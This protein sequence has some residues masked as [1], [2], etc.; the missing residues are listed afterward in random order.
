MQTRTGLGAIRNL[1]YT[2]LLCD[3][4]DAMKAFYVERLGFE[5]HHEIPGF[6]VAL[7]IGASLLTLRPRGRPYDGP[8]PPISS[9]SVQLAFRVPPSDVNLAAATLQQHGIEILEP[10]TDQPWGHRTLFFADPE[11][12][13]IE[14]YADI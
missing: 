9:A 12:N 10:P 3:N 4:L 5:I 6:W 11:N 7:Q 2:I 14:I 1:D 13:V 8:S